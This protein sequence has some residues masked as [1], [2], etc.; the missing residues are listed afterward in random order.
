MTCECGCGQLTR[1]APKTLSARG[2]VKDEPIRF[3]NGH[4]RRLRDP[5][6]IQDRG[7]KTPCW[8][9]TA[10]LARDGYGCTW[11]GRQI[12]AHRAYYERAHGPIPYGL[13]LDHLCKVVA[14]VNPDHL[15]PVTV[16]ENNRRNPRVR[17]S[18]ALAE[19]IR[20]RLA[21]GESGNAIAREF[22]VSP[23]T[24]SKVKHGIVWST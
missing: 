18:F 9:W 3:V 16:A 13:V 23:T 14:C 15:E 19:S 21:G 11:V 10:A 8:I 7:Y 4:S 2:W 6:E 17:L 5:Y 20:Q 12:P 1:L 24:I 22:G